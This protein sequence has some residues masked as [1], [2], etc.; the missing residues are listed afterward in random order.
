LY[1]HLCGEHYRA[2]HLIEFRRHVIARFHEDAFWQE[3][4]ELTKNDPQARRA[5]GFVTLLISHVTGE[6][7][8]QALTCWTVDCLPRRARLWVEKYGHKLAL[9]SFPGSKLYLLLQEEMQMANAQRRKPLNEA[10]VPRRWPPMIAHAM[11]GETMGARI[12]RYCNQVRFILFRLR[13]HGIE[14][15][16]YAVESARWRN[17]VRRI[18]GSRS[19]GRNGPDETYLR[20]TYE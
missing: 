6:F 18:E 12:R 2:S 15:L 14:G 5:L 20:R 17:C 16:R 1:K 4:R 3:L 19:R 11:P 13:F 7:A 8:P 9:S 10:L